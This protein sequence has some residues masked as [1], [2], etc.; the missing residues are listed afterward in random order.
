V[1]KGRGIFVKNVTADSVTDPMHLYLQMQFSG[2][3]A[4]HLVHA[5]QVIEPPIAASAA[6][7]HTDED[8]AKLV[9][10][11]EDL[12][13]SDGGFLEL[14]NLDMAFHLNI[15]KASEN[16]IIPLILE[17]IHRLMPQIKSSVYAAVDDAKQ[18]A[19]IWH[20]KILERILARDADGAYEAMKDHLN[21][22]ESHIRK[23]LSLPKG[24][25][26]PQR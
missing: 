15:A 16:P 24:E 13:K 23:M 12:K 25:S 21:I 6:L 4:L 3:H 17:P 1:E 20:G 14:A 9:K 8:A 19:V 18:S 10:N 5:R 26:E 11:Y 22:A 2:E 7:Y